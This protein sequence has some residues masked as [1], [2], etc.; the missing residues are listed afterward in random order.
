MAVPQEVAAQI[1]EVRQALDELE[2]ELIPILETPWDVLVAKLDPGS[3]AKLT[4]MIAYAADS[5][6]FMYLKTQGIAT[7]DHPI[8]EELTRIRTYMGKLKSVAA[9]ENGTEERAKLKLNKEAAA[10]FIKAGL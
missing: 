5:L 3:K 8:T 7:E 9:K 1:K 4:L 2:S 10:R 6:F